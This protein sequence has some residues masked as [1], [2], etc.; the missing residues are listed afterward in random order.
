M[1]RKKLRNEKMA[2]RDKLKILT[3]KQLDKLVECANCGE[4]SKYREMF[5]R[6]DGNNCAITN[7]AKGVCQKCK[8]KIKMTI[9]KKFAEKDQI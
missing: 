7:G 5:F 8:K 1:W 6:V 2:R 4:K 3:E 9:K